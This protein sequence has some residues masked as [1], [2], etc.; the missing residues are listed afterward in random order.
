MILFLVFWF[1]AHRQCLYLAYVFFF[2]F[3]HDLVS[4]FGFVNKE[5]I[6]DL[7]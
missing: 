2:L 3:V 4:G 5:L 6:P 7:T 1:R